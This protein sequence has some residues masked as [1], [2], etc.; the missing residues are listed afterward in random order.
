MAKKSGLT[1]TTSRDGK[2]STLRSLTRAIRILRA[3]ELS[4][5]GMVLAELV[6]DSGLPKATVL[7][8]A[9]S[10][11]SAGIA[12]R[13]ED[14]GRFVQSA[15][16][17][18]RFAPFL[19]PA[20]SL[21]SEVSIVLQ[22]LSAQEGASVLLLLPETKGR[23]GTYPLYAFPSKRLFVDPAAAP[24]VPLHTVAGGKCYLAHLPASDLA[25]YIR[26]GL[27][28]LTEKSISSPSHLRRE[29]AA[30]RKRGYGLNLGE[31]EL[32]LPGVGVP[33][34]D[35]D[36]SV[37]GGLSLAYAE[38][39]YTESY[40]ADRVPALRRASEA[41]SRLLSYDSF[42][43]YMR[44]ADPTAP[45]PPPEPKGDHPSAGGDAAPLVRSVLRATRLMPVLWHSPEGESISSLAR[46]RG[47]DR[48]TMARLLRTLAAER[49]VRK[50]PSG[51]RYHIDPVM[52]LR[53]APSLRTIA[54]LGNIVHKVLDRLAHYAGAT[55]MLVCPGSG[56]GQAVTT[57]YAFPERH[58]FYRPEPSFFPPLHSVGAGKCFL[59]DQSESVVCDYIRSGLN[60]QTEHTISTPQALMS[61]LCAVRERGHAVNR[62]ECIPGIGGLA[63]SVRSDS[64]EFLGA[65]ALVPMIDE[66]TPGNIERWLP[67]LRV[68]ADTLSSVLT[69]DARSQLQQMRM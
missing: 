34:R 40:L 37:I 19:G 17:W 29:L 59:A 10:L 64:G 68:V 62:E 55:A 63:V 41:I 47:L 52:W 26:G 57:V 61:E 13:D 30:V 28:Q 23:T 69:P 66:L 58:V 24:L 53:L 22:E 33:L 35:S 6:R 48:A 36:G 27:R 14:S 11:V 7:R 2:S 49:M 32:C 51:E 20:Q 46:Q 67:Q 50:A 42:R 16:I 56:H 65:V 18:I 3:I 1:S 25:D 60:A 9:R 31:V 38:G 15:A 4:R 8:L 44:S 12:A 43:R 45:L 21:I 5:E 54:S 39:G